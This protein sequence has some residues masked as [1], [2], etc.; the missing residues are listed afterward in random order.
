MAPGTGKVMVGIE[1][2]SEVREAELPGPVGWSG[3]EGRGRKGLGSFC[4]S[5]VV[6]LSTQSVTGTADIRRGVRLS[7]EK[8]GSLALDMRHQS[9]QGPQVHNHEE[10][11]KESQGHALSS[12]RSPDGDSGHQ[13]ASQRPGAA[14]TPPASA[15]LP[16]TRAGASWEAVLPPGFLRCRKQA[17]PPP[18]KGESAQAWL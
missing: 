17:Y 4:G 18:H 5:A 1:G 14:T 7:P 9:G 13:P 8:K 2:C 12:T 3:R 6:E 10:A 16:L 15:S 11:A